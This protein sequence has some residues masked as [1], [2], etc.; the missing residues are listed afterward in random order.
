ME[1]GNE[2]PI[3]PA[4]VVELDHDE[5]WVI[6]KQQQLRDRSSEDLSEEY[7]VSAPEEYSY[8]ILR[9]QAPKLWGPFAETEFSEKRLTLEVPSELLLHDVYD[10]ACGVNKDYKCRDLS[11]RP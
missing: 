2:T 9:T 5:M 3:I 8:W 6:A 1:W 10:Y 7:Q 4:K 11:H